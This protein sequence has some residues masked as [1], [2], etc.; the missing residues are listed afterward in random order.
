MDQ[1]RRRID[2]AKSSEE[3]AR[4]RRERRVTKNFPVP[5]SLT[6]PPHVGGVCNEVRGRAERNRIS[7]EEKDD[8]I[9]QERLGTRF[10]T[11]REGGIGGIKIE[12]DKN[13]EDETRNSEEETMIGSESGDERRLWEE[14]CVIGGESCDE[15]RDRDDRVTLGRE[16]ADEGRLVGKGSE[17]DE[18][19]AGGAG[20]MTAKSS[21]RLRSHSSPSSKATPQMTSSSMETS[22]SLTT[23]SYHCRPNFIR[24]S[25][26][27]IR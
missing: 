17:E 5:P 3:G 13:S 12:D 2:S 18:R 9:W 19:A 22:W 8:V 4:R 6:T 26:P 1:R 27:M 10:E 7:W 23:P 20:S 14:E 25:R 16:K 11:E 24:T 15:G 21:L